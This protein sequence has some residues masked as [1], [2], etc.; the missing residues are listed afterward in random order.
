MMATRRVDVAGPD[1]R[2]VPNARRFV[3]RAPGIDEPD[4]VETVVRRG[5]ALNGPDMGSGH[6]R[7]ND[8]AFALRDRLWLIKSKL[9][10]D[11]AQPTAGGDQAGGA[12]DPPIR[13]IG[14]IRDRKSTRLNSSH[15][16]ESRMPSSA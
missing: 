2:A 11:L 1:R 12:S 8:D 10:K 14:I 4:A 16:G 5:H 7:R 9:G 15:S 13:P 6:D 3:R